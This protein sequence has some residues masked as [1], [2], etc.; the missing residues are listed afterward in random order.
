[1]PSGR[2]PI[3]GYKRL[4]VIAAAAAALWFFLAALALAVAGD[5]TLVVPSL[6]ATPAV[7]AAVIVLGLRLPDAPQTTRPRRSRVFEAVGDTGLEPVTSALSR[8][9][10]PS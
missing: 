6:V 4:A 2:T 8:R 5:P 3:D 9:R 1:M 7:L 10:S